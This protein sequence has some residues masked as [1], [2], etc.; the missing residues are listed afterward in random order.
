MIRINIT[1]GLGNQLFQ[2]A[3]GR[4][5]QKE[6]GQILVLNINELEKYDNKRRFELSNYKLNS[7]VNIEDCILPWYVHRRS[8]GS[9][10]MR[11]LSPELMRTYALTK[12]A[13][14]WYEDSDMHRGK[15]DYS[16]DIYVGGYWQSYKY[17]SDVA[18]E[19]KSEI[20]LKEELNEKNKYLQKL[21]EGK[22]SVCVHVRRGDYI[23]S[24]HQICNEKYYHDAIKEM[25]KINSNFCFFVFS[26]EIEWI[27]SNIYIPTSNV[28]YVDNKNEPCTELFLM[29]GCKHFIISN[30]SFSWW[31]QFLSTYDNKIVIA[32]SKWHKTKEFRN[33]YIDSWK[34][35]NV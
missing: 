8:I 11:N 19:I 35:I 32:P 12:N 31:A 24:E 25:I 13:Y 26:D 15:L 34:L 14:V 28:V 9:K 5:I 17:F 18:E 3:F 21:I 22:D 20:V 23:G 29:S 6:S 27:K 2:Y 4:K 33:I 16:K 7:N 1:G 30:S 10:I